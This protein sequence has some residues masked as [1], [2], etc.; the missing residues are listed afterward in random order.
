MDAGTVSLVPRQLERDDVTRWRDRQRLMMAWYRALSEDSEA[1]TRHFEETY[2]PLAGLLETCI[3][4]V[5]DIGGGIGMPRSFLPVGS[6][7]VSLEPCE[8]WAHVDTTALAGRY[9]ALAI[10][11]TAVRGAGEFVPFPDN[12]FDAVLA[13]WTLNYAS[14]AGRVL[15]EAERVLKPGGQLLIVI[16]NADTGADAL[17]PEQIAVDGSTLAGFTRLST[18]AVSPN[19]Q[20]LL[21]H[22]VKGSRPAS[23]SVDL[24]DLRKTSPISRGFGYSRG[25]PI[26][27]VYIEQFLAGHA[28]LVAGR[29]LEV[30]D[31][32]YTERFGG[33][34]VRRSDVLHVRPGVPGVTFVA[35]LTDAPQIDSDTFDCVICTQ[36]LHL[37]YDVRAAVRTLHRIVK[38]GGSILCTMPGI[39][40]IDDG[41]WQATWYWSVTPPAAQ[42]LF[43]EVFGAARTQVG[44]HGNVLVATGFLQGLAAED[45]SPEEFEPCDPAYPLVVTVLATKEETASTRRLVTVHSL[46]PQP[47]GVHL[48]SPIHGSWHAPSALT[49]QGW[50]GEASGVA[51]LRAVAPARPDVSLTT[52]LPRPD[53]AERLP[54]VPAC[55]GFSTSLDT[56]RLGEDLYLRVD[57]PDG[58][59]PLVAAIRLSTWHR[60]RQSRPLTTVVIPC[61]NHSRFLGEAIESALSQTACDI[62]VI[63]VDDGSTDGCDRLVASFPGVR[64]H[65]QLNGGLPSA[66]NAGLRLSAGDYIVFL[67]ADDRLLGDAVKHGLASLQAH[68]HAVMTSGE[69]RYIDADG[70]VTTTW[71]RELPTKQHYLALLRGNYVGMVATALFRREALLGLG[72]FDESLGA[73]EDYDLYLRLARRLELATHNSV[74]AE[75]RRLPD[76]LSSD[77]ALMLQSALHVLNRAPV[78]GPDEWRAAAEGKRYWRQ[79]YGDA[80]TRQACELWAS[81]QRMRGARALVTALRRAP[82]EALSALKTRRT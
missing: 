73:C 48:D 39:S 36:T 22:R 44:V 13:L 14:D 64:Y 29:V 24:G 35:D 23:S 10:P 30:G 9:P 82:H 38:P 63:V 11:P 34:R 56:T 28:Q 58:T 5:L 7:Y 8:A 61:F 20:H 6:E 33:P 47:G 43:A 41:E 12:H 77:S 79:L 53:V 21:L 15:W 76:A 50:C 52:G 70:A 27:R 42:R 62:E 81:G 40:P 19:P 1:F 71:N 25:R 57:L 32:S 54:G 66:R 55:T 3:G 4:R 16:E 37:I 45:L 80:A 67:D 69:H 31:A 59:S 26:D 51:A 78:S 68:E 74:V 2:A 18:R 65:Y 72:G 49:I 17:P 46:T 60:T 75:Y